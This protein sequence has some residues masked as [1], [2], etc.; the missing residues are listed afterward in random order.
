MGNLVIPAGGG[1]WEDIGDATA[2]VSASIAFTWAG[3]TYRQVDLI[4]GGAR[5]ATDTAKATVRTSTD[6]GGSFDAGVGDYRWA[7]LRSELDD[8]PTL[9]EDGDEADAQIFVSGSVGNLVDEY[10]SGVISIIQPAELIRTA[11]IHRGLYED[12]FAVPEY[13]FGGGVRLSAAN[14][15]GIQFIFDT[16]GVTDGE[17]SCRGLI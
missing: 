12:A 15:D 4:I 6:G 1:V 11:I 13:V 14:V 5:P 9:A 8:A 16:G 7:L 2:A 3:K 17:F 10:Y